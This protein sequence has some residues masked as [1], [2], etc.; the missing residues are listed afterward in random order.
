MTTP[1]ST[2]RPRARATCARPLGAEPEIVIRAEFA[3]WTRDNTVRQTAFKGVLEGRDP[4]SVVRERPVEVPAA[5]GQLGRDAE[6]GERAETQCTEDLPSMHELAGGRPR[7]WRRDDRARRPSPGAR[8]RPTSA[9][10]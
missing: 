3:D 4:R 1:R 5:I 9:G 7:H 6:A 10:D 2:R 8:T